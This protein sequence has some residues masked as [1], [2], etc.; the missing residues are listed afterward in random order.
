MWKRAEDGTD[1][2]HSMT[3]SCGGS[4]DARISSA[5]FNA[6]LFGTCRAGRTVKDQKNMVRDT[7][8]ASLVRSRCR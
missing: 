1:L 4:G 3:S 6:S 7:W 2:N 8:L 5:Q